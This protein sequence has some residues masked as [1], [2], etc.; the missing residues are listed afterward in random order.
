MQHLDSQA[1]Q[2]S[3]EVRHQRHQLLRTEQAIR[4][5][6]QS[7]VNRPKS[8]SRAPHTA[9]RRRASSPWKGWPDLHVGVEGERVFLLELL[10]LAQ[11]VPSQVPH[12]DISLI[13]CAVSGIVFHVG[14]QDER[15][16]PAVGIAACRLKAPAAA[17]ASWPSRAASGPALAR[18]PAVGQPCSLCQCAGHDTASAAGKYRRC[19]MARNRLGKGTSFSGKEH[20]EG[21]LIL[22]SVF[23]AGLAAC[24]DRS[25]PALLCKNCHD[26]F[27]YQEKKD[28]LDSALCRQQAAT[29]ALT[30]IDS[31]YTVCGVHQAYTSG[32]LAQ[33]GWKSGRL[34]ERYWDSVPHMTSGFGL[35]RRMHVLIMR[36]DRRRI[37]QHFL[38]TS[39]AQSSSL[40]TAPC[41]AIQALKFHSIAHITALYVMPQWLGSG[42][43]V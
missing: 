5:H 37:T 11:L 30:L 31:P 41:I 35:Y 20:R 40:K 29:L 7:A 26:A 21:V 23:R 1:P 27:L 32:L 19:P 22:G 28:E 9:L 17:P 39:R 13:E 36:R 2:P 8:A 12:G 6:I 15:G 14:P 4:A 3:S 16:L 10:E 38:A 24:R 34:G 25:Y 18:R 43:E 42:P 33:C